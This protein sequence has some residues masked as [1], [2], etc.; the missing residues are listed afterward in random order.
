MLVINCSPGSQGFVIHIHLHSF[1]TKNAR[2]CDNGTSW[3]S[4]SIDRKILTVLECVYKRRAG[5]L[6][7][8]TTFYTSGFIVSTDS[9]TFESCIA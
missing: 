7:Y 9:V 6:L 8:L 5:L 1:V 4:L 2:S 3:R